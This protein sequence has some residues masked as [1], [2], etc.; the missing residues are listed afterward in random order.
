M[1]IEYTNVWNFWFEPQRLSQVP[2]QLQWQWR[3]D[4]FFFVEN[5]KREK[6]YDK[7]HV[8]CQSKWHAMILVYAA[9]MKWH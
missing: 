8:I 5:K 4:G 9:R 6:N 3:S 2:L 1:N 7:L